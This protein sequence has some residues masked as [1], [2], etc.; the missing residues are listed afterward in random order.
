MDIDRHSVS[1][2]MVGNIIAGHDVGRW[3]YA[4]VGGIYHPE[5]SAS[6]GLERGG[7][8]V[9][10]VVFYNWNGVSAMASIAAVSPLSRGFLGAIFR[11]PFVVGKLNQIIVTIASYNA[12]SLRLAARMGFTEQ[13]RLPDA[14]PDGDLILMVLR[15]ENCRFLGARYG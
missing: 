9:A 14:H 5:A 12:R 15:R 4:R 2:R 7:E 13:A 1:E 10:G 8:I 3:V 6:I 11:Y